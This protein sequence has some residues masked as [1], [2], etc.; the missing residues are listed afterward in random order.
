MGI[1]LS[2]AISVSVCQQTCPPFVLPSFT[3]FAVS[4][5]VK[6]VQRSMVVNDPTLAIQLIGDLDRT[7]LSRGESA[8]IRDIDGDITLNP[9]PTPPVVRTMTRSQYSQRRFKQPGVIVLE[10]ISVSTPLKSCR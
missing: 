2:V 10:S 3:M 9:H 4:L 5:E 6:A 8:L 7:S 1:F